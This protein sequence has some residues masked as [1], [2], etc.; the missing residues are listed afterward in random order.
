MNDKQNLET[1]LLHAF[2][3]KKIAEGKVTFWGNQLN[4]FIE[5]LEKIEKPQATTPP[6][7]R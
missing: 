7:K 3:E 4:Y 5:K 1:E 2:R 6:N